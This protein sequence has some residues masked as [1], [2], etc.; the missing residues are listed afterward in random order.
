MLKSEL[1][2]ERPK[3]VNTNSWMM[4]SRISKQIAGGFRVESTSAKLGLETC[5]AMKKNDLDLNVI[6]DFLSGMHVTELLPTA[7]SH[8]NVFGPLAEQPPC[9]DELRAW[10]ELETCP[11]VVLFTA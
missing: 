11:S 6:F 7:V 10:L 4:C 5:D 1:Q 3:L 2:A 8:F 9:D